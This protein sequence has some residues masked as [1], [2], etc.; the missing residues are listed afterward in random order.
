MLPVMSSTGCMEELALPAGSGPQLV[1]FA[2]LMSGRDVNTVYLATGDIDGFSTPSADS[3]ILCYVNGELAAVA[4]QG[5]ESESHMLSFAL[6]VVFNTGDHVRL[7]AESGEMKAYAENVFPEPC[8]IEVDST[9]VRSDVVN[10]GSG[11]VLPYGR[12]Y[13]FRMTVKDIPGQE[14]R[15]QTLIPEL[16]VFKGSSEP[17]LIRD[18]RGDKFYDENDP[19]FE[20]VLSPLPPDVEAATGLAF[21]VLNVSRIFTDRLFED[22]EYAF[23]F[24]NVMDQGYLFRNIRG[25]IKS[26]VRF[27]VATLNEADWQYYKYINAYMSSS[28]LSEPVISV[29]NVTGGTGYV[30]ALGM[31]DLTIELKS[32]D[33]TY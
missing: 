32:L 25:M 33:W 8:V 17:E 12:V 5:E 15:F 14:T 11:N 30:S 4:E 26:R 20:N 3:R 29:S 13:S 31:T 22:A 28:P 9:S 24:G 19:V 27:S 23:E 18:L 21:S 7:V 2:N 1:L 16:W 6:P 10:Y